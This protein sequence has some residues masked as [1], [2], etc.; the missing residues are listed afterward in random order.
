[1]ML[2][3]HEMQRLKRLLDDMAGTDLVVS[4]Q[5]GDANPAP[6]VGYIHK[7]DQYLVVTVLL[8]QRKEDFATFEASGKKA[9]VPISAITRMWETR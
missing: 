2:G 8:A 6:V 4:I 1:M 9:W 5:T 7:V 3:H